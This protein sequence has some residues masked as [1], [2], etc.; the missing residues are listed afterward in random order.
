MLVKVLMRR[1]AEE[2]GRYESL[3]D[4][5]NGCQRGAQTGN[6][7]VAIDLQAPCTREVIRDNPRARFGVPFTEHRT[8]KSPL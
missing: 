2:P 5:I 1:V 8:N 7:V 3:H 6:Y 4:G